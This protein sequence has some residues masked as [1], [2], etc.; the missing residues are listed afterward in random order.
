MAKA[1]EHKGAEAAIRR[2]RARRPDHA[3]LVHQQWFEAAC[4][5]LEL[6]ILRVSTKDNIADVPSREAGVPAILQH[7]G[8]QYVEPRF[9]DESLDAQCWAVLRERWAMD[10]V[11]Y[12]GTSC[13]TVDTLSIVS[14]LGQLHMFGFSESPI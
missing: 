1:S 10:G 7:I 3:R 4:L 5:G 12:R 2:G 11:V 6:Y 9:S 14:M 8:A 13:I